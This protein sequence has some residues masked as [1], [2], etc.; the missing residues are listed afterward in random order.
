[1]QST[2]SPSSTSTSGPTTVPR[3]L[4]AHVQFFAQRFQRD[5][6]VFDERVGFV[7]AVEGVFVRVLNRVLGAVIDLPQR[8]RQVGALQLGEGVGDQHGLHELLGHADVEE[9]A[10]LLAAAHLD[11]AAL[12]VEVDVGEAAHGDRQ[13]WGPCSAAPR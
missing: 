12:L 9:R 1:M 5:F 13:A 2:R 6:E 3:V 4:G 10:R 7:L 11:D 8:G